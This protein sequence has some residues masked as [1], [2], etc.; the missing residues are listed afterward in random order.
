[1]TGIT[2]VGAGLAG[3]IA[4]NV[5]DAKVGSII[6]AQ[7]KLPDNHSAVLRFR[8][9]AIGEALG[10]DFVGRNVIITYLPHENPL[11]DAMNY[12]RKV[13]NMEA[14]DRSFARVAVAGCITERRWYAPPGLPF[15]LSRACVGRTRWNTPFT[16]DIIGETEG[17]IISTIPMPTLMWILDW[18][19]PPDFKVWPQTNMIVRLK[20]RTGAYGTVYDPDPSRPIFRA[21]IADDTITLERKYIG[22]WDDK[23]A[24]RHSYAVRHMRR[25]FGKEFADRIEIAEPPEIRSQKMA[26]IAPIDEYVRRRFMLWA[27]EAH[28]IYSLGR[29][30]VWRPGLLLDDV[31]TD[32]RAIEKMIRSGGPTKA[33]REHLL[34]RRD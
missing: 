15:A 12:G 9:P 22:S 17:P 34:N 11:A 30:A 20:E 25:Y 2:I 28:N 7:T 14:T 27:T 18:G 16:R 23:K 13:V 10:V 3:L 5:L 1:M 4:A 24:N 8:S 31:L 19:E 33:Y 6:E 26:K 29:Y 21:S 32:V